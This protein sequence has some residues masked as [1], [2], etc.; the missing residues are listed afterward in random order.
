MVQV[1][2][3]KSPTDAVQVLVWSLLTLATNE[4]P[5]PD[6]ALQRTASAWSPPL[7]PVM[8]GT[9]GTAAPA[10]AA[11]A[12]I[13]VARI[14]RVAAMTR[15]RERFRTSG[16]FESEVRMEIL[17]RGSGA[18]GHGKCRPEGGARS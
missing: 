14:D 17:L 1:F 9:P 10:G 18:W 4:V 3:G 16:L 12:V 8:V 6:P 15:V 13:G 5:L 11:S 2:G 7:T